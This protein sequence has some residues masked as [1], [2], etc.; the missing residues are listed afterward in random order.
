M[1][2]L[3]LAVVLGAFAVFMGGALIGYDPAR[4]MMARR[5]R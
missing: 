4:G 2:W 5:A 1:N 3:A